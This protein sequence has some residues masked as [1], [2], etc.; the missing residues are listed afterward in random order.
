MMKLATGETRASTEIGS[1]N[2]EGHHKNR[3]VN[4]SIGDN[5]YSR[6][7]VNE[8]QRIYRRKPGQKADQVESTEDLG[9]NR[10][11]MHRKRILSVH[12]P[13]NITEEGKV[14][15]WHNHGAIERDLLLQEGSQSWTRLSNRINAGRFQSGQYE[16]FTDEAGEQ[17]SVVDQVLSFGST[18]TGR[19]RTN[20]WGDS[21]AVYAEDPTNYDSTQNTQEE[22]R[23]D[24]RGVTRGEVLKGDNKEE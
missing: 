15:H 9:H 22:S 19:R 8:V 5:T 10:R 1:S 24:E 16:E 14:Q 4:Q 2:K 7:F 11:W 23:R 3:Q 13:S 21:G 18:E 20:V 17:I 6:S 12:S